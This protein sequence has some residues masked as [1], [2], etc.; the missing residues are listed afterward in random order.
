MAGVPD[1]SAISPRK[2]VTYEEAKARLA[3]LQAQDDASINPVCRTYACDHGRQMERA[4][5]YF[6][7]YTN[8]PAQ[9]VQ[10]GQEFADK[11]YNVVVPRLPYHGL[12]NRMSDA[13]ARLA[14]SELKQLTLD[15][16]KIAQGMGQHVAISGL[17]GGGVMAAWAAQNCPEVDQAVVVAP[18]L[19]LPFV[20][21]PISQIGK[22][23]VQHLPNFFIWWDPR[24][25]EKIEGTPHAYPRFSTRGLGEF[26]RLGTE[27]LKQAQ[28]SAPLARDIV[29]ITSAADTAVNNPL[30]YR[31][32]DA[33]RARA[34]E[35]IRSYEFP[36][37]A[38][39]FHDMIDPTQPRQ[40]TAIVY[41]KWLDLV[42]GEPLAPPENGSSMPPGHAMPATQ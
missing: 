30:V 2:S 4:L 29:V 9:F 19:G 21:I 42:A 3:Q 16:L 25:K 24:V 18:S 40:R 5:V 14:V 15:A 7:G 37:G 12:A 26:M 33:W 38:D 17:S 20:P 1:G 32:I 22:Y 41:P 35:R 8:C 36:K 6:H 27:V 10:L 31:L 39:I 34:P 11:G 23:L 13:P 28:S